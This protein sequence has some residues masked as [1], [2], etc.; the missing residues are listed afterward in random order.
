MPLVHQTYNACGPASLLQVLRYYGLGSTLTLADV[1]RATRPNDRAYMTSAAIVTFAPSAGLQAKLYSFGSLETVRR[2]IRARLPLIAL[3][4]H[5]A[6]SGA[7]IPHWRVIVGYDDARQVVYLM[8]PL[9]SY[10]TIT[11]PDFERVWREQRGQFAVLFPPSWIKIV[12]QT[13]G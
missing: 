4:N 1:S 8:D 13:I 2:A 9:L 10:V 3:Q 11:Y 12:T 5:Y 7:V 6:A